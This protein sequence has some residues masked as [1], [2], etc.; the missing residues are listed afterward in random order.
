LKGIFVGYTD[1]ELNY[2]YD[3]PVEEAKTLLN[4][5]LAGTNAP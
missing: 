5:S 4:S 2:I 1:E 3:K